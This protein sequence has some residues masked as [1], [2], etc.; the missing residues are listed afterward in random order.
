MNPGVPFFG[1]HVFS[2][3]RFHV[4]VILSR[5]GD[6]LKETGVIFFGLLF[7]GPQVSRSSEAY[8]P[9]S[10]T[11]TAKL[12]ASRN[13]IF[14]YHPHGAGLWGS[15]RSMR[16]SP[17][18]QREGANFGPSYNTTMAMRTL[19]HNMCVRVCVCPFLKCPGL[20]G[21]KGIQI[22]KGRCATPI[23]HSNYFF[24]YESQSKTRVIGA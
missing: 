6:S 7:S 2:D 24:L 8:F 3:V 19:N 14:G 22:S 4:K 18:T 11:R 16:S 13:Y 20:R 23:C 17:C 5:P 21:Q 12:D 10:L 9:M 1:N 15:H